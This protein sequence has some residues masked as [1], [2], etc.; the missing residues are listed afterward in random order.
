MFKPVAAL[1]GALAAFA[2]LPAATALAQGAQQTVALIRVDV[3]KVAT[4]HRASKLIGASVVNDANESIGKIDDLIVA[5]DGRALFAVLSVGGFL[6]M[7]DRLVAVH[8]ESLKVGDKKVTLPG[9]TKDQ[10]KA[11]PEFKYAR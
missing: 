7:G 3:Q 8:E 9:A 6:G 4:G 10:L 1:A 5:N 2:A 11:L